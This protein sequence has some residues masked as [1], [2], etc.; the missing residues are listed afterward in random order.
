MFWKLKFKYEQEFG[1]IFKPSSKYIT[2]LK[3]NLTCTQT[4]TYTHIFIQFTYICNAEVIDR[5]KENVA[6][7]KGK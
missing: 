6:T 3:D 1:A 7:G 5:Q 4:Y 2:F